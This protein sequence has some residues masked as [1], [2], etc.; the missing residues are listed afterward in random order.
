V[1]IIN[2]NNKHQSQ[3][4]FLAPHPK[5]LSILCYSLDQVYFIEH[6]MLFFGVSVFHCEKIGHVLRDD[7]YH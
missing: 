1:D 5:E 3:N 6:F 7:K 4:C 2:K